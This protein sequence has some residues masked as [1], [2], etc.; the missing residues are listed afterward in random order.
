M[1]RHPIRTDTSQE[2]QPENKKKLLSHVITQTHALGVS[3]RNTE[4]WGHAAVVTGTGRGYGDLGNLRTVH[5][6]TSVSVHADFFIFFPFWE[7]GG[8]VTFFG[9]ENLPVPGAF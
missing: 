4:T 7:G 2:Q 1:S 3:T 9:D 5:A 8:M 6:L